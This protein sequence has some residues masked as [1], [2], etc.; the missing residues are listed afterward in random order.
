M[1]LTDEELFELTGYH[2]NAER[3][4]WLSRHGWKFETAASGRPVVLRKYAESKLSEQEPEK[5]E[6][7]PNVDSIRRAA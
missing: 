4:A 6:W 7:S 5:V 1:F 2:R 3:R